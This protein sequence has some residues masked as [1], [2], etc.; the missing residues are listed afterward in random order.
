MLGGKAHCESQAQSRAPLLSDSL[1]KRGLASGTSVS[2][3]A[4]ISLTSEFNF[5]G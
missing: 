5:W 1:T 2:A 4:L 3:L